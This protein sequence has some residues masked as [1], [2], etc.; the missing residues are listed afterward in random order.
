GITATQMDGVYPS[1]SRYK[2]RELV[3]DFTLKGEDFEDLRK[4]LERLNEVFS[5]RG[6]EVPIEFDDEPNSV[7]RGRLTSAEDSMENGRIYEASITITCGNPYKRG[8]ESYEETFDEDSVVGEHKG[9]DL[10][11]PV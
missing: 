9:T 7:Y 11:A 4:K 8:K 5:T 3:V 6:E 2:E 1:F 10:H